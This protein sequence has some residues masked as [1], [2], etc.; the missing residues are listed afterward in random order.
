MVF[1]L[2]SDVTGRKCSGKITRNVHLYELDSVQLVI[3]NP[4]S[5][6]GNFELKFLVSSKECSAEG[7]FSSNPVKKGIAHNNG[8]KKQI[9]D[10]SNQNQNQIPNLT[11]KGSARQSEENNYYRIFICNLSLAVWIFYRFAIVTVILHRIPISGHTIVCV[12]VVWC[13]VVWC[14]AVR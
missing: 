5:V 7:S 12:F 14:G 8:K 13:G 2:S 1:Q 4:F 10:L 6:P 11:P 9:S 3:T